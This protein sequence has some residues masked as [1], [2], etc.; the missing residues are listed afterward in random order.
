MNGEAHVT[1]LANGLEG[2]ASALED[3]QFDSPCAPHCA[4]WQHPAGTQEDFILQSRGIAVSR[5]GA[6]D[7]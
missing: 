4:S 1:I 3:L 5:E 2:E 6:V 7:L